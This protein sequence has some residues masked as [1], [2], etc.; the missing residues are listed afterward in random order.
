MD[1]IYDDRSE[2]GEGGSLKSRQK[3]QN[4]L[5]C[6][7]D[8][9]EGV[10]KSENVADYMEAPLGDTNRRLL[11]R[12]TLSLFAGPNDDAHSIISRLRERRRMPI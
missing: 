4:Q 10:N 2:W 1:S 3:E 5:I 7:S 9:G 12:S 11:S 8:R 6:D